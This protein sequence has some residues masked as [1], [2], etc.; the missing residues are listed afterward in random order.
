MKSDFNYI[1]GGSVICELT[2]LP[3]LVGVI[4]EVSSDD[5]WNLSC[6]QFSL[7]EFVWIGL[8][9]LWNH[10]WRS[11]FG[12]LQSSR[13]KDSGTLIL[14][15]KSRGDSLLVFGVASLTLEAIGV[16]LTVVILLVFHFSILVDDIHFTF[17]ITET[18]VLIIFVIE[19]L[20]RHF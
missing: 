14:C 10:H 20:I 12:E 17:E 6:G 2:E 5:E 13:S 15:E 9:W 11:I 8:T 4:R 18:V 7:G 16:G 1:Q 19:T 3:V